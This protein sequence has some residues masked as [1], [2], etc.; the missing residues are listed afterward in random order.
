MKLSGCEVSENCRLQLLIN[1]ASAVYPLTV[2]PLI[3]SKVKKLLASDAANSDNFGYSVAISGDTAAVS[4]PFEGGSG[5]N[6]GAVYVF[7]HNQGSANN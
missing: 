7:T 4:A 3:Y 6:R 2:D 1:S 5:S